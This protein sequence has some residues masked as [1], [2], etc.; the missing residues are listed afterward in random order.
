MSKRK[1]TDPE[2]LLKSLVRERQRIWRMYYENTGDIRITV[3]AGGEKTV[4]REPVVFPFSI[5][6]FYLEQLNARIDKLL[7]EIAT[8]TLNA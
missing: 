2:R 7:A 3:T 8:Q 4:F 1:L 5:V 6:D